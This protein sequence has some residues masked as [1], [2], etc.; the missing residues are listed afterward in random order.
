M[1]DD[2]FDDFYMQP[3]TDDASDY[4]EEQVYVDEYGA[5][6]RANFG[7]SEKKRGF[8]D[9][10]ATFAEGFNK[11]LQDYKVIVDMDVVD[12]VIMKIQHIEYINPVAFAISYSV[13]DKGTINKK[14]LNNLKKIEGVSTTDIIRYCRFWLRLLE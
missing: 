8:E 2:E 1:S 7:S 10:S 4:V 5:W 12:S 6:E 14:K 3:D 9:K 11:A 13:L